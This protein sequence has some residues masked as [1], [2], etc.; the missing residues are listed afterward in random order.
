MAD[1]ILF[2]RPEDNDPALT[3]KLAHGTGTTAAKTMTFQGLV[4]WLTTKL[5][6]LK[7]ANN[8]SD[9]NASTA[10][11]NISVYSK[12]ESDLTAGT[13][14]DKTNVLER[15]NTGAYLPTLDYH[16]ATKKY[17][18]QGGKIVSWLP[19]ER[20]SADVVAVGF[21]VKFSRMGGWAI[22]KGVIELDGAPSEGD[23]LFNMPAISY[24]QPL[25][26]ENIQFIAGDGNS[27]T[28]IEMYVSGGSVKAGPG[29]SINSKHYFCVSYPL[30]FGI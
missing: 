2:G 19:C 8:L 20:V 25:G 24:V 18:D 15:N 7:T 17:A 11:T 23:I 3:Q 28:I 30:D 14:A 4:T 29:F 5:P 9:V 13:K 26:G 22:I 1:V 21:D 12:T 27:D 10:R 16:P 6:F